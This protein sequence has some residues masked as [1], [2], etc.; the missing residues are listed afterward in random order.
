MCANN[1][2]K[3]LVETNRITNDR[4]APRENV[5][6]LT[7]GDWINIWL[8]VKFWNSISTL[9][10]YLIMIIK[11]RVVN[12]FACVIFENNNRFWFERSKN[13]AFS[14]SGA[15]RLRDMFFYQ[16]L[17]FWCILITLSLQRWRNVLIKNLFENFPMYHSIH[18]K[19]FQSKFS[20]YA[21]RVINNQYVC[22]GKTINTTW[23][24]FVSVW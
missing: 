4:K 19:I 8:Y 17:F 22:I 20:H 12:A 3:L 21:T 10:Y 6:E 2:G 14:F 24:W 15:V 11:F 16:F 5:F 23:I 9:A 7:S 13:R 18:R 1:I